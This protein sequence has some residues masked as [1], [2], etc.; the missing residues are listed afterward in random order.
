MPSRSARFRSA[1]TLKNGATVLAAGALVPVADIT[2]GRLAFTPAQNGNGSP[3]TSFTFQVQDDG[4]TTDGGVDLDPTPNTLTIDV[5]P[6]DDLPVAHNDV[7]FTVPESAG[8]TSLAVLANDTDPDDV[9]HIVSTTTAAHGVVAIT[10]GGTGLT[11]DPAQLYFGTDTFNYTIS[12]G[13]GHTATAV[14]LLTVVRDTIKPTVIGPAESFYGQ[15]VATATHE[16]S[17]QLVRIGWR[18][19]IAKFELQ[20]SVSGGAFTYGRS[21][22]RD[23]DFDQ[24]HACRRRRAIAIRVRATDKAGNV[25]AWVNGPTW[26][27]GRDSRTTARASATR[28]TGSPRPHPAALGG[29]HR[30]ASS[31]ERPRVH[32]PKPCATSP[33]WRPRR[34]RAAPPRCGSTAS[35]P[36]RST[37]TSSTTTFRQLVF[38]RHFSTLGTHTMEIRPIG[39]GLIDLDAFLRHP[40]SRTIDLVRCRP[41]VTCY[42]AAAVSGR[43]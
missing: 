5:T 1:G 36:R 33:G 38:S 42:T 31:T 24:P 21:G 2:A 30:Y 3:Y 10:G 4:G 8:P 39:G 13:H 18:D 11:Y 22:D 23:I 34:P 43:P 17:H 27:A 26:R 25:S 7:A 12:D 37:C 9:L 35:L 16:G 6:V 41:D 28:A 29:S 15:T 14:V 40:L 32:H 19:G 20:V